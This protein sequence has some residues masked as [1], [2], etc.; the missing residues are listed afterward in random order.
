MGGER[1]GGGGTGTF[2]CGPLKRRK[3]KSQVSNAAALPAC[4]YLVTRESLSL[5][6]FS[7]QGVPP[8]SSWGTGACALGPCKVLHSSLGCCKPCLCSREGAR[9]YKPMAHHVPIQVAVRPLQLPPWRGGSENLCGQRKEGMREAEGGAAG[10]TFE[11]TSPAF[12]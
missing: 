2:L 10:D 11:T 12:S 7:C 3:G 8:L 4:G 9:D 1:R 5:F 6:A